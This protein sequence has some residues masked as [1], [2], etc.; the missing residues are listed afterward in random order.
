MVECEYETR[1]VV[2]LT[3]DTDN[4]PELAIEFVQERL[5]RHGLAG[6][7]FCTQR[8]ELLRDPHE[9]ATHPFLREFYKLD[10]MFDPLD[11]LMEQIPEAVG[12]RCH[13][14]TCNG[15]LYRRLGEVGF[16][17]DSGWPMYMHNDIRPIRLHTGILE[18]PIFYAENLIIEHG[19]TEAFLAGLRA[20]GLKVFLFHPVHVFHN[21]NQKTFYEIMKVPYPE[22]YAPELVTQGEGVLTF[23]DTL[24]EILEKEQIV[25]ATCKDIALHENAGCERR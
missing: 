8:Y 4:C 22:R 7:F 13:Q 21:S 15:A 3:F 14:L 9:A 10:E 19:M 17:Y 16:L 1:P 24:L 2:S 25:V 20:P 18:L 12:N 23:F 5:E 6:T 11:R